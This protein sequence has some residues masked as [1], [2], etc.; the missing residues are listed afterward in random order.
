MLVRLGVSHLRVAD[1]DTIDT[2]NINRQVIANNK[3]VGTSKTQA[4]INELRT[5][6]EDFEL[7]GYDRGVQEDMV[8]EFVE[9]VDI[10]IDEID[11]FPLDKHL[12]LHK[13]AQKRNTPIY[14]AYIVGRWSTIF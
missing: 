9:G 1:P 4:S 3:T 7:V 12:L 2:S 14:S 11:V 6:A 5:I 13:A 8:D 10:I